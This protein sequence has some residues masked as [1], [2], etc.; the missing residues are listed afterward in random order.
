M[1][2]TSPPLGTPSPSGR[3]ASPSAIAAMDS[4]P[5]GKVIQIVGG[6]DKGL[7]MKPMCEAL[8]L[9]CKAILTIGKLGPILAQ[10]VR[11]APDRSA[12]LTECQTLDRAVTKARGIATSGDIVLL[13]TG[14]ASYDQFVNFEKRGEEFTRFARESEPV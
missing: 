7:D 9:R 13:S 5:A 1:T 4:F 2:A 8:A 11:A 14:C 12:E 6:Y 10:L 3:I